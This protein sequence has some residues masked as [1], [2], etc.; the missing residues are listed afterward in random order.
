MSYH[1]WWKQISDRNFRTFTSYFLSLS[2]EHILVYLLILLIVL[3][4]VSQLECKFHKAGGCCFPLF[5]F[6]DLKQFLA[7]TEPSISIYERNKWNINEQNASILFLFCIG[8]KTRFIT[9]T[10]KQSM[11]I[12]WY[13]LYHSIYVFLFTADFTFSFNITYLNVCWAVA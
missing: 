3:V 1:T 4:S 11:L 12:F 7:N 9:K 10:R 2:I 8:S 5:Y 13:I 6:H